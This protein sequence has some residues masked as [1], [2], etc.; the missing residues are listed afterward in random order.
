MPDLILTTKL[1][2]PPPRPKIVLRPRL[3]EQ[4][5]QGLAL[6]CKLT[7]LSA[8]AGFGKST[9]ASEWIAGCGRPV[10][11]ISLDEGDSD[12]A[13]FLAYLVAALQTIRP[14]I[15]EGLLAALQSPEPPGTEAV[16]TTLL[17]E[18]VSVPG[19]LSAEPSLG[20][21]AKLGCILVMDDY[22]L[23]DSTQVDQAVAFLVEHLPAQLHLVISTREDPALPLA[24][25]RARGQVSELRAI[26]MRFSPAEAAEFLNSMMGL[27]LS[28]EDI[29]ALETRTEGWI[30]GLQMAA[31]S[32]RG[33]ADITGFIQSF[34]GSHRFVL[35]YL[36]EE[37]LERQPAEIQSFLLRT[38]ILERMCG[39]VCD[40]VLRD[41]S[42][43][44]QA[45][46]EFLE[47]INLF[48]IPL[49][50]ERRWY[51][52][53]HLF[54]D[55][56]RKRLGLILTPDGI[57]ALNIHASEWY[58]NNDLMLE[59][60]RHAAAANDVERAS[61][62]IE[63]RKM[64]LHLRGVARTI[65]NWLES[66]PK[67]LLDA[68]PTLWWKQAAMLLVIGEVAGVEGILQATE[69]ALDAAAIPGEEP[70]QATRDL[71]GKIAAARA[72]VAQTQAQAE[73]IF[74]QAHRAL[75]YLHPDN[76]SDRSAAYR[77]LGFAH[78]IQG[79]HAEAARAYAEALSLAQA[80]RDKIN[81]ILASIRLGQIQEEDNQLHQAAETYQR[82][83]PL[84]DDYSPYNAPVAYLGLA[85]I[86]YEWDDLDAAEMY[87]EK[88]L[89]LARQYDQVID[90]L[91]VSEI[92][93]ARLKLARRDVPGVLGKLLQAEQI[94][95]L[96]KYTLRLPEIALT[97]ARIH[98]YLGNMDEAAQLVGQFH[99]P[100]MQARVLVAQGNPS[101]ALV[102]VEAQRQ[103]A[104]AKSLAD[105]LLLVMAVQSVVLFA[106]GE[107]E[108]AVELLSEVLAQAEPEGI[109]RLFVDEGDVMA[110]LLSA[111]GAQGIRPE[112]IGKLLAAFK[113]EAKDD[114]STT[115]VAG[116]ALLI[117]PIK[118]ARA[119]N[120]K[121][122]RPGAI[123][124]RD[125]R[126]A[127]PGPGH[128]QG[129]QS[130]D[131]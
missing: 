11:W 51:R 61:R 78:F 85:R 107:K 69:A 1:F 34:T 68:R 16:M 8:P 13:R 73:T 125:R 64:P 83:L 92:F 76:L 102:V 26:E 22:H 87:G 67:T 113:R 56:L 19:N 115:S 49:D 123:Q 114:Q 39:P 130:Q 14:G 97:R 54:G 93:L 10:A 31:I 25:L 3:V 63:S 71:V 21:F 70:D 96:K 17:N 7:L 5:D 4:L 12:P 95:H 58:E 110:E 50:N 90:R 81:H 79:E 101:A 98:L 127:I 32:M 20:D 119:G 35:D 106:N 100:L 103:H 2:I 111:A 45:T 99:I 46:L 120:P 108:K 52:Y 62:L 117:E 40:A 121:V 59:A 124:S 116:S 86:Y 47:R 44:G 23:V 122:D 38:S 75:E 77:S 109:I 48:I 24:R 36:L 65:L 18:F 53:H 6:G 112:Y 66:L 72:N 60:F 9:L 104:E 27:N 88:S 105:R 15:G 28:P 91:I 29:L 118:P 82:I 94:S 33:N 129:A 84:L 74:F 89:Q 43:A 128:D 41:P 131:F 55:L 42:V 57:A 30:A 37:V 80:A 126:A